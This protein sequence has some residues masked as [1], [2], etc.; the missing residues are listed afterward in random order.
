MDKLYREKLGQHLQGAGPG[1]GGRHMYWGGGFFL[2]NT[3]KASGMGAVMFPCW[4][5]SCAGLAIAIVTQGRNTVWAA[6]LLATLI[7]LVF[8]V[9]L[10][11]EGLLC[12]LLAAPFLLSGLGVGALSS[13]TCFDGMLWNVLRHQ[14]TSVTVV[15]ALTPALILM[16]HHAE[17]P[18]LEAVRREIVSRQH[19]S[20][21]VAGRGVGKH[22]VD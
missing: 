8:L 15:F 21:G 7:S 22:T 10:R 12:A 18:A 9:A 3:P 16:G 2:A 1:N 19:I 4:S 20:S 17:L 5:H 14:I 6:M 13:A 11:Y